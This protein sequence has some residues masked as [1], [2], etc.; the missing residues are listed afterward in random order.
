MNLPTIA[1]PRLVLRAIAMSDA[2]AIA[3]LGGRDF[4]IARWLTGCSWPYIDGE[5]EA[6]LQTVVDA[7]PLRTEAA[8]A[9]TLDGV[10]IGTVAIEAPG[11]IAEQAECPS[12]GYWLGRPFHGFGY[13]TEAARAALVWGFE[14]HACP[15]IVARA[16]EDNCRSRAV[17]R[18]LGFKPVGKTIRFAKALD[19]KVDNII[20]RLNRADFEDRRAAA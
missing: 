16:F 7:D 1:T 17:L 18:K 15:A 13:A 6:F 11:E 14:N 20:V 8:F 4:E 9:V 19:R 2:Q 5:A 3:A 12:L 10:F